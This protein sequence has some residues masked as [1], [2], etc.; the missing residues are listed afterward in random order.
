MFSLFGRRDKDRA[1]TRMA[2]GS[3]ALS[4][5]TLPLPD[6]SPATIGLGGLAD[7][8]DRY[9][10]W[11]ANASPASRPANLFKAI[12]SG[13]ETYLLRKGVEQNYWRSV[14]RSQSA[15][16]Q[17]TVVNP[18]L[19]YWGGYDGDR[20]KTGTTFE[21]CRRMA[22]DNEAVAC[23]IGKRVN[24]VTSYSRRSVV[25]RGKSSE[26]GF[27][28]KLSDLEARATPDDKKRIAELEQFFE[29][30]GYV[31][32]PSAERPLAWQPGFDSFLS[33][34]TRDALTLDH[35]AVRRWHA[36]EDPRKHPVLAFACVDAAQIQFAGREMDTLK[37][38][39]PVWKEAHDRERTNTKDRIAYKKVSSGGQTLEEFTERELFTG[40]R[41][42]RSDESVNGYGFS[43]IEEAWIAATLW[44]SAR[45]FNGLRFSKNTL[46]RGLWVLFGN[47]TSQAFSAFQL[48]M[49]QQM[50][51]VKN[52]MNIPVVSGSPQAGSS[53]QFVPVDPTPKDLEHAQSL[54]SFGCWIHNLYQISPDETGFSST[55]PFR[56]PLSEASPETNLKYS[57]DTG[58][59][60]LLR[61]I[62]NLVNRE[63]LWVIDPSRKF[64]FE[65]VG[66]GDYDD[67][68]PRAWG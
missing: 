45:D 15:A 27:H 20:E 35:V 58:L 31:A 65:F 39:V 51:G 10:A 59:R 2:S 60:P 12:T 56:P 41:R 26:P 5:P 11:G 33:M 19:D 6:L 64:K 3:P 43:E 67:Y 30:C 40:H 38:G 44:C 63:L 25:R 52:S 57:Q 66:V 1:V 49:K 37:D 21:A 9:G 36:A 24:Q 7:A 47:F 48:A 29:E 42:H 62:E 17:G 23:I 18:A 14:A 53:V 13:V 46:P 34:L 55:S 22:Q 16:L 32:P 28:I 68:A 4:P 50:Q 61:W 8:E 54:F